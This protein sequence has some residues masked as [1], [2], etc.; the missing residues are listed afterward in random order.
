[1]T[2]AEY[3]EAVQA[4]YEDAERRAGG[5]VERVFGVA[6]SLMRLR[7]A[8]PALVS[9]ATTAFSHLPSSGDRVEFS[10]CLFD[11]ASTGTELP[12]RPWANGP[13]DVRGDIPELCDDRFVVSY[14][15]WNGVLGLLDRTRRRALFWIPAARDFPFNEYGSPLLMGLQGWLVARGL[16]LMHA[17]AVGNADGGVL[18]SGRGGAGKS[19]TA[20]A[21][22][23]AGLSY[24]ADDYCVLAAHP[25]PVAHSLYNSGKLHCAGLPRFPQLSIADACRIGDDK[26]LFFLHALY[27][28]RVV[29]SMPILAVVLPVI[30]D[31]PDCTLEPV[32]RIEALRAMVS[33]TIAQIPGANGAVLTAGAAFVRQLPCYRLRIG[34]DMARIA[35]RIERLLR[36]GA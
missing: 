31:G 33:S 34:S 1:M 25:R 24:V 8:G 35:E 26:A 12:G 9:D 32:P 27:P 28:E 36:S 16:Q 14:L 17:G 4:A 19:T 7:F 3:F 13:H 10:V 21:C 15:G 18:L 11:S 6:G 2:G 30:H 20:I 29:T 22:L 5:A 23:V